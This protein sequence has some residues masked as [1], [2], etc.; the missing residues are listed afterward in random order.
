MRLNAAARLRSSLQPLSRRQDR[1]RGGSGLGVH[2]PGLFLEQDPPIPAEGWERIRAAIR[3]DMDER[4]AELAD[5]FGERIGYPHAGR[6]SPFY[7]QMARVAI[8]HL[9]AWWLASDGHP[10][11]AGCGV[12]A[13]AEAETRR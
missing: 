13:A 1:M 6:L 12:C 9:D 8:G 3:E 2:N 5:V 4:V 10:C 7:W 11:A